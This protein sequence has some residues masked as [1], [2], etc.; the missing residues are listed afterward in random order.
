MSLVGFFFIFFFVKIILESRKV[1][2]K[3]KVTNYFHL[4][5]LTGPKVLPIKNL[6]FWPKCWQSF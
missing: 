6:K 1:I 5:G 2:F 4:V 3:I